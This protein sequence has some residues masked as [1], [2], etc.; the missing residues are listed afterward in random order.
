MNL[1]KLIIVGTFVHTHSA[2][3]LVLDF[4]TQI[5]M[6]ENIRV[7]HFLAEQRTMQVYA[8]P[9]LCYTL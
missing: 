2:S 4:G 5:V 3:G 7:V 6:Q 8:I 1:P 9:C